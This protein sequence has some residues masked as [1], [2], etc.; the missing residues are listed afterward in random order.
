[1]LMMVMMMLVM[2]MID[3]VGHDVVDDDVDEWQCEMPLWDLKGFP[4][5][6]KCFPERQCVIVV[7]KQGRGRKMKVVIKPFQSSS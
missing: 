2:V 6:L 4:D 7:A 3:D 5:H 1:M